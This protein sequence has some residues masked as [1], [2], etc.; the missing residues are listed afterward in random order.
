MDTNAGKAWVH[1][2]VHLQQAPGPLHHPQ[3][4]QY[5]KHKRNKNSPSK[6]RRRARRAAAREELE[7]RTIASHEEAAEVSIEFGA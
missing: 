7:D 1:L 3:N 2:R 6:Q 5:Q 4:P